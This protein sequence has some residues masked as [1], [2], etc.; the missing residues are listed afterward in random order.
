[1]VK[2]GPPSQGFHWLPL[3]KR[4]SGLVCAL[5]VLF[6]R[7]DT[8]GGLV[9]HGGDIDNRLKTFL[10]ALRVPENKG[11]VGKAIPAKDEDPF[12]CLLE[13]DSYITELNVVTDRLLVPQNSGEHVNDVHLVIAVKIKVTDVHLAEFEF[14]GW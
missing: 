5:D 9:K 13:D 4:D 12:Y 1:M 8:P 14:L 7:R 3:V 6:L 2:A 10:D 11:E